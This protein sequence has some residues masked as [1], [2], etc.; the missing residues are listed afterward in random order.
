MMRKKYGRQVISIEFIKARKHHLQACHR[1]RMAIF[2]NHRGVSLIISMLINILIKL[3]LT[4]IFPFIHFI[5][6]TFYFHNILIG[7][8]K[9]TL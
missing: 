1:D 5:S 8:T 7:L 3:I 4:I 9:L 6:I 2:P